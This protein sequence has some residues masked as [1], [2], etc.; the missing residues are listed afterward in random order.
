[1]LFNNYEVF[2]LCISSVIVYQIVARFLKNSTIRALFLIAFSVLVLL[3]LLK[4]HTLIVLGILSVL[5][6]GAG[7]LLK[8]KQNNLVLGGTLTSILL[9]FFIRNYTIVQSLIAT[10]QLDFIAQPILSVQK[11][12]L[13]YI[14][15]RYVHW[16]VESA[17]GTIQKQ[18]L[19][20]FLSYV[21]FFPTYLA[22]PIDTYKNFSYWLASQRLQ[23]KTHLQFAGLTRIVI[24]AAKVYLLVP[25]LLPIATQL[26]SGN[27][28]L[29]ELFSTAVAYSF[30]LYLDFSGYSDIAIG[31]GYLFGIKLPENFNN[32]YRSTSISEFWKRWHIT[33]SEFLKAYV[34]KPI[35]HLF[36]AWFPNAARLQIS[37]ASYL[38]TFVI[39]GIW[40]GDAL[41]FVVWG[42]WH[43]VG[44]SIQ[45][46]WSLNLGSSLNRGVWVH[47]I[48]NGILTFLFVSLGWLLFHF[49]L[50]E[51]IDFVLNT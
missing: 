48:Y 40:H 32:P 38:L 30:Y 11:V 19:W 35:V 23:F 49:K 43:G 1:M 21:F 3:T 51:L 45:K 37:I 12:G 34:F 17:R 33:F 36:N 29:L 24:G 4:E 50:Q 16:L 27:H 26:N 8:N 18:N 2:I 5:V 47:P 6:Y 7:V 10:I 20:V 41:H 25:I 13:S 28:W 39:C 15:F 31:L 9:L 14:L 42:L 22:G 44:L 46:W